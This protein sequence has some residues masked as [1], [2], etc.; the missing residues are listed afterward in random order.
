M[1]SEFFTVL[2]ML[3][4][5]GVLRCEGEGVRL[6]LYSNKESRGLW[7][8]RMFSLLLRVAIDSAEYVGSE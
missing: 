1:G 4:G 3:G 7:V 5:G 8:L 2:V 6:K